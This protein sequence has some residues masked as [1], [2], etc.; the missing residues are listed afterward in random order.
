[1]LSSTYMVLE[2]P[3]LTA[4]DKTIIK[5]CLYKL[6]AGILQKVPPTMQ[7]DTGI[8]NIFKQ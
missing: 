5:N 7:L 6:K 2:N 1:M 3:D 4:M 8:S